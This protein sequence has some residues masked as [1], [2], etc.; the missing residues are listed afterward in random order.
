MVPRSLLEEHVS[1]RRGSTWFWGGLIGYEGAIAIRS[2][3]VYLED[4]LAA[5]VELHAKPDTAG[6]TGA[7]ELPQ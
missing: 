3:V 4:S 5:A 1:L 7:G 6:L 2:G